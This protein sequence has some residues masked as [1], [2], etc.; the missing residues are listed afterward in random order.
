MPGIEQAVGANL[1][2]SLGLTETC[3]DGGLHF[4]FQIALQSSTTDSLKGSETC[5][6]GV[7]LTPPCQAR[8]P[9]GEPSE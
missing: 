6:H 3:V 7:V 1:A 9:K 5:A 4:P 2:R 8:V